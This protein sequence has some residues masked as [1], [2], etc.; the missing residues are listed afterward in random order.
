[1]SRPVTFEPEASYEL[2]AAALWYEAQRSGLGQ[3]FLATV[4]HLATWPEAGASVPGVPAHL[5]VRQMPVV[6][7]PYRVVY[8]AASRELRVL[9]VAHTRRRPGYWRSRTEP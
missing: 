9:A 4:D 7:F 8:L 5:E 3:T 6:R 1:M 2:E